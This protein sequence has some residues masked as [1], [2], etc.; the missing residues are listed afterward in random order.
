MSVVLLLARLLLAT[1]FAVAGIA[2]LL[3][4]AG[5]RKSAGDFGVPA[6]LAKPLAFVLPLVELACSVALLRGRWA[7]FGASGALAMLSV[8]IAAIAVS[9]AR[10]RKPDCHC[11]GQ[12]HSAPIGWTTLS[13]N[14]V[15]AGLAALV[16]W[17]GPG[18]AG[19]NLSEW[20]QSL[21]RPEIAVLALAIT[22]AALAAFVLLM[23][24]Q[25]LRQN[26]RLALRLEAL[27]ARPGASATPPPQG[28]PV[29]SV[30]PGFSLA[31]LDGETVTLDM[32]RERGTPLLLFF[33]EPG[34]GACDGAL[35]EVARWQREH[36]GRLTVVPISRGDLQ[37]NRAKSRAH[38]L[39]SVLLQTD[40]EVSQ[41]Y[42]AEA[43]PSAVVIKKGLIHSPLAV[44]I[45]AIRALVVGATL[46]PP[47]KKGDRVPSLRLRDLNGGAMDL[48]MLRGRRTLLLFWNPS[49]GFCQAMLEDVK[50]WDRN[51]P[52]DA[53][54]LLVI[55]T[56]SPAANRAE[57]FRSRVLL[58]PKSGASQVFGAAGTPSA[59]LVDEEGRVASE[60][61]AGASEVFALAGAVPAGSAA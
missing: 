14:A 7:W 34:C 22:V 24:F 50:G 13:R 25:L 57:G 3:D 11:F 6:F 36:A 28:L 58:D 31:G 27:E 45:D 5:S 37:V 40:R 55:S 2:K 39:H 54:E 19:A 41:A 8:F 35:P 21:S 9:L 17:R 15:L 53:P 32:L 61:R 16:V 46:P 33:T 51:R 29:R 56:G 4:R 26:G 1:V 49:C 59:L 38:N 23:F 42:R 43:T 60:V 44:G 47:L 30:A 18:N 10:G 20:L 12:L 48:A 52:N